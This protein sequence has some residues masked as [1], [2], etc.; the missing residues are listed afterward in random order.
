MDIPFQNLPKKQKKHVMLSN[1]G[2]PFIKSSPFLMKPGI[3]PKPLKCSYKPREGDRQ[4]KLTPQPRPLKSPVKSQSA[5]ADNNRIIIRFCGR[6][7]KKIQ[8]SGFFLESCR[9]FVDKRV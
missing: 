3:R 5:K 4:G 6:V 7:N 9:G 1:A 8:K 2:F